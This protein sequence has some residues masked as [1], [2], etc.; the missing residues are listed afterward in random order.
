MDGIIPSNPLACWGGVRQKRNHRKP[1]FS[2]KC[3][4]QRVEK[5]TEPLVH[6]RMNLPRSVIRLTLSPIALVLQC[7]G[8]TIWI[9]DAHRGDGKRFV[10]HT[11]EKL[12]AFL[13]LA[14]PVQRGQT[15]KS[16]NC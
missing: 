8:R 10:V 7:T 6:H 13:G 4:V 3:V 5:I 9:A 11:D 15:V 1:S 14:A 2:E 12:T 16:E